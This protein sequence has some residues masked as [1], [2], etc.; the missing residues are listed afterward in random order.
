MG[1]WGGADQLQRLLRLQAL[2]LDSVLSLQTVLYGS[3]LSFE[4]R[5]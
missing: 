1:G 3:L 2:G 5:I 4:Q